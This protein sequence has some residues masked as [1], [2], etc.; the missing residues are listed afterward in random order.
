MEALTIKEELPISS[1]ET[2][3]LQLSR[4]E[5]RSD[6]IVEEPPINNLAPTTEVPVLIEKI[7]ISKQTKNYKT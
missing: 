6:Q 5:E 2:P 7:S 4:N 3:L 1:G